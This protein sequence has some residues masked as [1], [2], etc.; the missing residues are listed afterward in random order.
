M[1]PFIQCLSSRACECRPSR[2]QSAKLISV[3][4]SKGALENCSDSQTT[5]TLPPK[6]WRTMEFTRE[7][8]L[9]GI[10][11]SVTPG[12]SEPE[13]AAIEERIRSLQE[14]VGYTG[15]YESWI[16]NVAPSV[17]AGQVNVMEES[18]RAYLASAGLNNAACL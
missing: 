5:S 14:R 13:V 6:Y 3:N 9:F 11:S 12:L 4:A 16:A 8:R 2:V 7:G 18:A 1:T 10:G 15:D 17:T